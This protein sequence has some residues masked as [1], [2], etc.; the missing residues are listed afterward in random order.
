MK[1]TLYHVEDF[2]FFCSELLSFSL[3]L[4][5]LSGVRQGSPLSIEFE[6]DLPSCKGPS[7]SLLGFS[8]G[9]PVSAGLDLLLLKVYVRNTEMLI[10]YQHICTNNW[11]SIEISRYLLKIKQTIPK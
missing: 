6:L 5:L 1:L 3:P 10:F 4:P 2:F 8:Q 9:L 7:H 11:K